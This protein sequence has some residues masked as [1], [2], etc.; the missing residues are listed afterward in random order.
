MVC[1]SCVVFVCFQSELKNYT[2]SEIVE[3]LKEAQEKHRIIIQ[4]RHI[5]ELGGCGWIYS[6]LMGMV[7]IW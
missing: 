5:N 3:R 7:E 2:W 4:K 6:M 1:V